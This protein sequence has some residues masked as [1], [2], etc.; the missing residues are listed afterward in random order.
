MKKYFEH[1]NVKYFHFFSLILVPFRKTILFRLLYPT[2]NLI[3]NL[4]LK[5]PFVG[6]YAWIMVLELGNPRKEKI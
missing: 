6:R 4:F 3:D 1:V 5:L 2:L